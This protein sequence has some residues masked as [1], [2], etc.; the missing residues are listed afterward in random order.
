MNVRSLLGLCM[1]KSS[2]LLVLLLAAG[3]V[4]CTASTAPKGAAPSATAG[5]EEGASA[6]QRPPSQGAFTTGKYRNVFAE[7]GYP[8]AEVQA[9]L[10]QAYAQLFHGNPDN[11]A[12]M[13]EAASNQHG[14]LAY[15]KDIGNGD[16]RSEGMSYGMMIAVQMNQKADF[17]ALWNWATT[18]MYHGDP[19]HPAYGYFAWQMKDDGSRIDDMPAPDGE[20]Y[21]IT[22]LLFAAHRWGAGQGKYNYAEQASTL[23]DRVKNRAPIKGLVTGGRETTGVALFNAETKMVRFTPDSGNFEKNTDHTDPS[24]HLPAFYELW[25]LWGPEADRAFWSEAA[26]TSREFF[27][28][29]TH[30]RTGLSPDYAHFDGTPKA[31]SWDANT[32][33]FRFDAFRTGMNWAMD[34]AWFA[35]DLRQIELSDRLLDFFAGIGKAYPNTYQI[36]GTPTSTSSSSGLIATNAAVT[37][38]ATTPKASQFVEALWRQPVP[39][40]KWRYYDGML[41]TFALLHLSGNFRIYAPHASKPASN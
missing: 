30:P 34:C 22:A 31:A 5:T 14:R 39:T 21:F 13:L 38:C 35:K 23:L 26:V 24:Y 36:D 7:L 15:I 2:S 29:S 37:M 41:Y 9:K 10:Q 20:E 25:A 28:K 3:L 12:V 6:L 4:H 33:Q 18:F 16:V 32:V 19:G 17:D 11:Q 40:G 27:V 8:E 1:K